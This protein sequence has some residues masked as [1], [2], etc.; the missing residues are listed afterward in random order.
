MPSQSNVQGTPSID[1]TATNSY[2]PAEE[3]AITVSMQ[4]VVTFLVHCMVSCISPGCTQA[5]C[6]IVC[7]FGGHHCQL[8]EGPRS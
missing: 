5:V 2:V 6:D 7:L 4:P 8:V 1:L 3:I